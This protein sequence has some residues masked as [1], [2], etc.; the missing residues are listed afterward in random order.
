MTFR[1]PVTKPQR[2]RS[3]QSGVR[4]SLILNIAFGAVTV[5]S[6]ALLGGV[7]LAKYQADHWT[8]VSSVNGVAISKDDVRGRAAANKARYERQIE[9]YQ[10]MRNR[11]SITS[12]EYSSVS[13][14]LTSQLDPTNLYKE[15]LSQLQDDLVVR[16]YADK[17]GIRI[18]DADVDAQVAK[19]ATTE[20]MRHVKIIGVQAKATPPATLPTQAETD[21]AKAQAETYLSDLNSG[22]SWDDV[23][24]AATAEGKA[25]AEGTN[26]GDLGL[27]TRDTLNLDPALVDTVFAMAKEGDSSTVV[28]SEDGI[29][30][31]ATV[32]KIMAS[33][34]DPDWAAKVSEK[35]SGDAF[36]DG[37]RAQ[38][39]RTAVQKSIEAKYVSGPTVQRKV[40]EVAL[41]PGYGGAGPEYKLRIMIFAPSHSVANAASVVSTDPAWTEAKTRAD[42]AYAQVKADPSKFT[43]LAKDKTV[44]DDTMFPSEAGSIPWVSA[45]ILY[46]PAGGQSIN[47]ISLRTAVTKEGATPGLLEPVLEASAG[48]VLI[49][50]QAVRPAPGMRVATAQLLMSMGTMTFDQAVQTYSES[51]DATKGGDMGW[52]SRYLLPTDMESAIF[53]TPVGGISRTL[54]NTS[55][56]WIFKIV[57]EETRTADATLQAKLKLT[58][59]PAWLA[60][61]TGDANIWTDTAAL[62]AITPATAAQ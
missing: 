20:E 62:T 58:V 27:V 56:L 31:I 4:R 45:S 33:F 13:S 52:V 42:A 11:G 41:L 25:G 57:S 49:D 24:A 35:S 14:S 53:D 61:Q 2:R 5:A 34:V 18:S 46:D 55:G 54:E 44:N 51:S 39:L 17:N 36:R 26:T 50:F 47:M 6:V 15:A 37:A 38:A 29:F 1:P 19:D 40:Q 3:R 12:D 43:T 60:K 9:N 59:W 16:Q 32:T 28:A 22:K 48:Y 30:R 8:P 23:Y 7:L 21:A 10:V